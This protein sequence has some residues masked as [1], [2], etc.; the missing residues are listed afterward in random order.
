MIYIEPINRLIRDKKAVKGEK[1]SKR[2]FGGFCECG[3]IMYQKSWFH[4]DGHSILISECEKCWKNEFINF[5]GR[6]KSGSKGKIQ[7]VERADFREFIKDFLS[8]SEFE[9]LIAKSR[10]ERYNSAA[11]SRAKKK[12]E[13]MDLPFDEILAYI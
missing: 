6:T 4:F 12:L 3:G 10:G 9:A 11:L 8:T 1:V 2:Y 7:V 5:N 13:E